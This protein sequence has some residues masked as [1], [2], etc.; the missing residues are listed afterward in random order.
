[1]Q[2]PEPASRV[3]DAHHHYWKLEAQEQA[4]RTSDHSHIARDY[5]PADLAHELVDSGV[6]ATVLVQSVDSSDENDRL[7]AYAASCASVA[8]VVGWLPLDQPQA[9]RAELARADTAS[10]NGVRCLVGKRPL[11][12]LNEPEVISLFK[13]LADQG[14]SWDIVPVTPAQVSAV[15]SLT[16]AVPG[17]RVVLDHL[18]RPPVDAAGWEPWAGQIAELAKSPSVYIKISVGIDVL[19]G[20]AQWQPAELARYVDWALT[21]FGAQRAMLASNWPVILLRRSYREAWEDLSNLV[22]DTGLSA[23]DL[24]TVQ[25]GAAIAAYR[26]QEPWDQTRRCSRKDP[27]L[28]AAGCGQEIGIASVSAASAGGQ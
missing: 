3:I 16:S 13:D 19:T 2:A 10:W 11:N 7:A 5:E 28:S 21:H 12:W 17:L 8:G 20:W 26:L 25:G 6:D 9:A 15:G 27:V 18:A 4:W 22:A 14:L 23:A 24:A 1:M